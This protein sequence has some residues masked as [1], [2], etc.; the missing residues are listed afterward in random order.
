MSGAAR[1]E[2]VLRANRAVREWAAGLRRWSAS[3]RES[4]TAQ[5][6][7]AVAAK[8]SV[9]QLG[10]DRGVPRPPTGLPGLGSVRASDLLDWLVQSYDLT[11]SEAERALRVA[12]LAAGY[13]ADYDEVSA[14]DAFDVLETAARHGT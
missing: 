6:Q 12:M 14:V 5:R 8:S 11:A 3:T 1:G 10:G 2:E 4:S 7:R 9:T 13:P